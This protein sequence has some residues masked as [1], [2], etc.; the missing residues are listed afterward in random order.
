[1]SSNLRAIFLVAAALTLGA[2][3]A[4]A[5]IYDTGVDVNGSGVDQ[6]WT[7]AYSG[8]DSGGSAPDA[9][10]ALVTATFPFDYWSAPIGASQWIKPTSGNTG[11][12]FDPTVDGF[13]TYKQT[14]TWGG[15]TLAGSF[16]ADNSVVDIHIEQGSTTVASLY[17]STTG[18]GGFATSTGFG[19][20]LAAGTYSIFF[21]VRNDHQGSG[22]PSGLD[23]A[24]DNHSGA[25][26]AAPEPSTWAMMIFGFLGVGFMS[27]RR[28]TAKSSFRFA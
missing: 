10:Q 18:L 21:E 3:S 17:N 16:L 11:T 24:F 6:R 25:G 20:G 1:M 12:S 5:S 2:G 15:G 4:K 13:Y 19:T 28:R 9:Y 22:N 23:V 27:Y 26:P 7:F 8:S 14:F